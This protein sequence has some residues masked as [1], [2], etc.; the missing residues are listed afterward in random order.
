MTVHEEEVISLL[1]KIEEENYR[2]IKTSKDINTCSFTFGYRA[3]IKKARE[4][5][6]SYEDFREELKKHPD[7]LE[8]EEK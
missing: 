8:E 3:G 2:K 4:L 6:S 7:L 1:K 5:L